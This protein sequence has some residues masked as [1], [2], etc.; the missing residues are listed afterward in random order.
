MADVED[1]ILVGA[2]LQGKSECFNELCR[3]YYPTLVAVADSILLDYHL[4]EDAAQEALA[5]ACRG[6]KTLKK[7]ES[8]G[9]WVGSICRNVAKDMLRQFP[10]QRQAADTDAKYESDCVDDEQG[11]ILSEA[12]QQLPG[13]LREVIFLRFY[14]EMSYGQ[15]AKVLGATQES[16]DGRIRRAKKKIAVYL[17]RKGLRNQV[18]L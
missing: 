18:S 8:F 11:K 12:V 17:K 10:R 7:P 15:M 5:A 9:A 6:L 3:R 2:A 14:N 4:A 16:I 1:E 13:R